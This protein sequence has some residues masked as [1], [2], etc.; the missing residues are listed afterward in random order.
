MK[1]IEW[2]LEEEKNIKNNFINYSLLF[3]LQLKKWYPVGMKS[4]S[5]SIFK[6]FLRALE[7]EEMTNGK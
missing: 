5:K 2:L 6:S 7:G 1:A 3:Q 4:E